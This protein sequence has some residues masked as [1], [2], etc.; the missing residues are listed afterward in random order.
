[1]DSQ[2]YGRIERAMRY[3]ERHCL[4]QPS[5]DA[6]AASI[7]LSRYHFQRLFTRWAGISPGRFLHCLTLQHAK[8]RLAAR[9]S[10]LDTALDAGLSGP[11]RLHDLFVTFEALTPGEYKR[12]GEGLVV[13]HGFHPSPFGECLVALTERGVCGLSFVDEGGREAALADLRARLPRA[14]YRAGPQR[15]APVAERVFGVRGGPETPLHLLLHGTNFQVKVWEALL[16][17]PAGERTTYAGLAHAVGRPG[18]AR[19]VGQAVGRNAIAVLI[20][21][22]RVIRTMGL[23]GQYRWGAE[24][25][26]LLLAWEAARHAG[27]TGAG[28]AAAS[29]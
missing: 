21:C 20:P 13:H 8:A 6:V 28:P 23:V 14:A 29:A 17:V 1:M 27:E 15:T 5:L 19:A 26:H 16:R 10:L 24:R 11:G 25:K 3:M 22:H 7:G 4:E 9:A 12:Q 18:A 2:D